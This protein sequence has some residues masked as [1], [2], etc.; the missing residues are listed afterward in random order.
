MHASKH[1]LKQESINTD[2]IELLCPQFERI[3][4]DRI[5]YIPKT[6]KEFNNLK[7]APEPILFD[8]GMGK[9]DDNL[10]LFPY[11]WYDYIP[12]GYE[13]VT[14]NKD[15]ETF[16]RGIT[17]RDQRFGYLPYGFCIQLSMDI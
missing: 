17:D 10:F 15:R 4:I 9:W 2:K 3:D 13:I 14:I 1:K 5:T 11:E 12:E 8:I 16:Q 6:V 7:K